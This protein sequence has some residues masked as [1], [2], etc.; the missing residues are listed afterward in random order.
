LESEKAL[1]SSLGI[2]LRVNQ[3]N[4]S[5]AELYYAYQNAQAFIFPSLYEGFGI[6]IIEA[7]VAQCPVILSK[8]SCFPE[9]AGA[10]AVYFDPTDEDSI[11]NSIKQAIYDTELQASLKA[12]G[13]ERGKQFT[14]EETARQTLD[15]YKSVLRGK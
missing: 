4:V 12:K 3:H 10:A 5:D 13:L 8:S 1:I 9:I 6:P 14:W 15:V 11:M 2:E 7:F